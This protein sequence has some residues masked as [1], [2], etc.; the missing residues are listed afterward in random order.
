MMRMKPLFRPLL[1]HHDLG[2]SLDS[3]V[4]GTKPVNSTRKQWIMFE[5]TLKVS[6]SVDRVE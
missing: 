3:K 5:D 2:I 6:L 4:K 1:D